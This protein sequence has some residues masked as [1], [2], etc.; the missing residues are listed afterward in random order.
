MS[1]VGYDRP[2]SQAPRVYIRKKMPLHVLIGPELEYHRIS[3][4][5]K[6]WDGWSWP[7]MSF[8]IIIFVYVYFWLLGWKAFHFHYKGIYRKL[9]HSPKGPFNVEGLYSTDN[10][11]LYVQ[12]AFVAGTSTGMML[13]LR[14]IQ[15]SYNGIC[16]Y[17][18]DRQR[19]MYNWL[20][21]YNSWK[22]HW[23]SFKV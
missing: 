14:D 17:N 20:G 6:N 13:T 11:T 2:A 15:R 4:D 10:S 9:N 7:S 16:F 19:T 12:N 3:L 18:G 1:L 5:F 22:V 8:F 21:N 23:T